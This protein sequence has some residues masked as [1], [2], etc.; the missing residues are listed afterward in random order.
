MMH[1]VQVMANNSSV[2]YFRWF[3]EESKKHPGIKLSFVALCKEKPLML[4][5]MKKIGCDCYWIPFDAEKRKTGMIRTF[6]KMYSLFKKIKPDVVHTH[7]FDDSLPGLAAA[8][9]AGVKVRV[10]TK[11][12]T[13]FHWHY[14]PAFVRFDRLNNRMATHIHA[15]AD[16]NKKFILE[17]ENA[18]EEKVFLVRNG[19]P[20]DSTTASDERTIN[21]IKDQYGLHGRF[22]IGTVA[23]LI[24][25]KGHGYIVEA[26]EQLVKK[27]PNIKF[28]FAGTGNASYGEELAAKIKAKGLKEHV[29]LAGWLERGAMPSFYKCLDLYLHPAVNEPFGFAISEAMMN[30]VPVAATRTGS[31]DLVT[32]KQEGFILKEKNVQDIV[33]TIGHCIEHP[34]QL[35][36]VATRGQAHAKQ[37]LDFINM[38]NGHIEL[39]TKALKK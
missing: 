1:I 33:D 29:V 11:Q 3:A 31:N 20:Y 4:E 7:L 13:T 2:P 15:V 17:K 22:V 10:I 6:F 28:I 9:L 16:E 38:W 27:Y 12:D 5:E 37:H 24:E 23:R 8:K 36:L 18:P 21:T 30:G 26:A 14:K 32:D 34:D 25:W 35:G 39:Y 19:F